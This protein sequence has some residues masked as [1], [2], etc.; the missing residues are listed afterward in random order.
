MQLYKALGLRTAKRGD[1]GI[2]IE[3]EASHEL[4]FIDNKTWISKDDGSLRGYSREYV[5]NGAI[6]IEEVEASVTELYKNISGATLIKSART[7]THVHVNCLNLTQ[8]EIVTAIAY[9]WMIED[10]LFDK[11]SYQRRNSRFCQSSTIAAR[12][13]SILENLVKD[14]STKFS[15]SEDMTKYAAI[16]YHNLCRLGT[17][18]F[19]LKEGLVEAAPVIKWTNLCHDLV[20]ETVKRWSDPSVM[21]E[22]VLDNPDKVFDHVAKHNFHY[23]EAKLEEGILRISSLAYAADWE[24]W[25]KTID[26]KKVIKQIPVYFDE[27]VQ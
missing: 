27:V 5:S 2:E 3:V 19:R 24:E 6:K 15:V 4:P 20:H 7:S 16:A 26:E 18:E 17:L 21:L 8:K 23:D 9:N 13:V 1:V 22:D 11:V 25:Q 12:Q 10:F 14:F